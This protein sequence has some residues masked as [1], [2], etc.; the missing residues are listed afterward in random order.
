MV[1]ER[2][3]DEVD[4]LFKGEINIWLYLR[5]QIKRITG[6][7]V[8]VLK[9]LKRRGV[10]QGGMAYVLVGWLLVQVADIVLPAFSAPDWIMR[11]LIVLLAVGFPVTLVISW[12]F[13]L[14]RKGFIRTR[15]QDSSSTEGTL[16]NDLINQVIIGVLAAAVI[17]FA[18]DKFV[19]KSVLSSG[20]STAPIAVAV[21]PFQNMTSNPDN[22]AFSWGIHDDLLTQ[23]SKINGFKTLSRTSTQRFAETQ[24]AI[25]QIADELGATVVLEGG[26]QRS[27]ER[28]R[29][30]AQ[31]IDGQSDE[32]LWAETYDR[33]LT[34]QNIFAIQSEIARAIAN[35]LQTTLSP[36][37]NLQLNKVPTDSLEAYD[38]YTNALARFNRFG[39]QD[40]EEASAQF[41]LATELD[42]GFASAWAGLCQVELGRYRQNSDRVH[43]DTAEAAC[44]QALEL[45]DSRVEVYIA[46]GA[47]YR[48]FGQYA[49]AEVALQQANYAKAE[50]ALENALKIDSQMVEAMVE[51]GQVLARQDRLAEAEAGLLRAQELAP[52]DYYAQSALF[53]FYYVYS[54]KPNR[55]ELA[56]L[57]GAKMTSMRPDLPASWNNLGTAHFM[58]NQYEEAADAWRESI[59]LSPTR[60]AYTNT[61]LALF[62]SG[63]Y[64]ESAKMQRKATELAPDDHR[65]WG[66]LGEALRHIDGEQ[67]QAR[68]TFTQAAKLALDLLEVNDRDW[69]T[70]GYLAVYLAYTG[71]EE[72]AQRIIAEA[73]DESNRRSEVLYYGALVQLELGNS[74]SSIDLLEEAVNRDS[75][76][77][78]LIVN[79]PDLGTLSSNPRFQALVS[80]LPIEQS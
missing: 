68:K 42:P 78:H 75:D 11:A 55:F 69:Q 48:Y 66:R 54:D 27:A 24:L 52:R 17:V 16:K 64:E 33:E 1:P 35:S 26:V 58:L 39:I 79:D 53:S 46:Q 9:E 57:H 49:R 51:L 14:T 2:F 7:N 29:I 80:P 15:D 71:Q 45:D 31:L 63:H 32:H 72:K 62:Y 19:W 36:E 30:N 59:G 38:A 22:D 28:V 18:L 25:P 73:L 56:A 76:Y 61:G 74:E 70:K 47:L 40:Y 5:G 10:V 67:A 43:F 8:T 34:T 13:D 21:L 23:L 60:T 37:E 20:K 44:A 50:A 4:A 6:S 41:L 3:P 12:L 77:R 65:A